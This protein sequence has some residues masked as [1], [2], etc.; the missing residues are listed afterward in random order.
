[1]I[2]HNFENGYRI[3]NYLYLEEQNLKAVNI[4]FKKYQSQTNLINK[5]ACACVEIIIF[6]DICH[7][8]IN[9]NVF[10]NDNKN[11]KINQQA[12]LKRL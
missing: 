1:M 6:I 11:H 2:L 7:L 4:P 10:K 5:C 8:S 9:K 3:E 12:D